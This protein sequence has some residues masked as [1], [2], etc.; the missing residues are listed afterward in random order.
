LKTCY[1]LTLKGVVPVPLP[2]ARYN[3]A[4]AMSCPF[5]MPS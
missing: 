4:V 3:E 2:R 5:L 1:Y